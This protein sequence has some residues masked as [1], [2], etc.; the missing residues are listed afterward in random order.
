MLKWYFSV[1]IIQE[2]ADKRPVT[3]PNQP[4]KL[5]CTPEAKEKQGNLEPEI[6]LEKLPDEVVEIVLVL[7]TTAAWQTLETYRSLGQT[8]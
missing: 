4:C 1:E 3:N 2:V 7:A 8:H 6:Y 5:H